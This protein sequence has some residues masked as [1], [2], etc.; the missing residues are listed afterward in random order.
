MANVSSKLG[1]QEKQL[2]VAQ[3]AVEFLAKETKEGEVLFT[4][5]D[6]DSRLK[7]LCWAD[8]TMLTGYQRYHDVF[9][10]DLSA[11]KLKCSQSI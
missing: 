8:T 2:F 5:L 9:V 10:L 3:K 11:G 4:K 7:H 6:E 1:E